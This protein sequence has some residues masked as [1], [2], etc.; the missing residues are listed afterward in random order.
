MIKYERKLLEQFTKE[1]KKESEK[2]KQWK[3]PEKTLKYVGF[4][5]NSNLNTTNNSKG[6]VPKIPHSSTPAPQHSKVNEY[7]ELKNWCLYKLQIMDAPLDV[8]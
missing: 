6:A 8:L 1:R 4:W 2:L 5:D 3:L 7:Y